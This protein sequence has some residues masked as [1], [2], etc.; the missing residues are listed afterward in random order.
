MKVD[1][2][3]V[4]EATFK[5][6]HWWSNWVDVAVYNYDSKP[7]LIQMRISRTNRKKF[8]SVCITGF[9][10]NLSNTSHI[11]DLTHMHKQPG[12]QE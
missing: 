5:R 4:E 6:F 2:L 8:R 12:G 11:G 9:S 1:I 7:Y 3:Q 10:N